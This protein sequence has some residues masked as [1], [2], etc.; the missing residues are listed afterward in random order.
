MAG[1]RADTAQVM[2]SDLM[3]EGRGAA[4]RRDPR[5]LLG[6]DIRA[7]CM[8]RT[9]DRLTGREVKVEEMPEASSA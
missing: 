6:G 5:V 8:A 9:P 1:A 7:G 2:G 4:L 3:C